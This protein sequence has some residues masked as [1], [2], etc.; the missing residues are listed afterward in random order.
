MKITGTG[1]VNK[2]TA[3]HKKSRKGDSSAFNT[4]VQ[5]S[6]DSSNAA[7]SVSSVAPIQSV[8][9]ILPLQDVSGGFNRAEMA[10]IEQG[11]QSIHMLDMLRQKL[12]LGQGEGVS[13]KEMREQL[14]QLEEFQSQ[15]SELTGAMEDIKLR[16]AVEIAKLEKLEN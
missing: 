3:S 13:L 6:V 9:S 7:N 15:D 11:E 2:S 8:G 14:A 1:L 5:G 10:A 4:M 16:L 12:L